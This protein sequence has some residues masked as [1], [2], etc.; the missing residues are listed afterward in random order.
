MENPD[1][2]ESGCTSLTVNGAAVEGNEIPEELL[3]AET[4]IRLVV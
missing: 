2:K 1:G 3:T 4:E